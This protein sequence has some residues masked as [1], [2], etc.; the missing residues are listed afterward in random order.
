MIL[1]ERQ[2]LIYKGASEQRKPPQHCWTSQQWH[3][4]VTGEHGISVEK[5]DFMPKLFSPD[6]LATMIK[7]REAFNP[8]G[9]LSP[10]KMLPTAAGC[11]SESFEQTKLGRRAA[12]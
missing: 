10:H 11:A 3:P 2:S 1:S 6:D 12:L 5:I 7:L 8:T 9:R 4:R